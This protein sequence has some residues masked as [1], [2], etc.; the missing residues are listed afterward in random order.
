MAG[1]VFDSLRP[2]DPPPLQQVVPSKAAKPVY[3]RVSIAAGALAV[4]DMPKQVW[5]LSW[6]RPGGLNYMAE[7]QQA[8]A[9]SHNVCPQCC[10]MD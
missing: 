5:A 7:G 4:A 2:E 3:R 6:S 1:M 8:G 9:L 10:P